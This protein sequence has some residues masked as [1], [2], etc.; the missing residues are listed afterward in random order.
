ML[1]IAQSF[2]HYTMAS[3]PQHC[4]NTAASLQELGAKYFDSSI[5][6]GRNIRVYK[7]EISANLSHLSF[8]FNCYTS[9]TTT[10]LASV[11]CISSFNYTD[12]QA[13]INYI[14]FMFQAFIKLQVSTSTKLARGKVNMEKERKLPNLRLSYHPYHLMMTGMTM[15]NMMMQYLMCLMCLSLLHLLYHLSH[16]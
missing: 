10:D 15:M 6:F 12:L 14:S 2:C 8:I 13:Y 4:H 11:P 16:L 7:V 5:A 9:A 1:P 3:M